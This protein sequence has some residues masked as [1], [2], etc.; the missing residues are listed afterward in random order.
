MQAR[1]SYMKKIADPLTIFLIG[2]TGDLSKKKILKAL[3]QLHVQKALPEQFTLVGNAR[4]KFSREEFV[5][6]AKSHI[7]P[8]RYDRHWDSF[9]DTLFY[10]SGDVQKIKTFTDLRSFH[11]HLKTC[12]NHLWYV[13]TL[14]ELYTDVITNIR[15]VDM[16]QT[17]CGWTKL[18]LEKPF[19]TNLTTSKELNS[20]LLQVFSEDQIY[21]IDHFLAKET[22]QNMLVFR[23]GNGLF[24]HLW[25]N[26]YV[27]HVQI[28]ASETTG[29]KGR[30]TFY[31][32]TGVV[33]DVVQNH[34][35]QMLA[36]TLME[37]P[38]Q[39]NPEEIREKRRAFL[40]TLTLLTTKTLPSHAAFG[41][42]S[43]GVIDGK[44][45]PGYT[46]EHPSLKKSTTETAVALKLFSQAERWK[47]VP[48]YIRA[49]KRMSKRVTEISVVF[50]EP[51]NKMFTQS[52]IQQAPNSLTLRIQPNEGVILR[53][54]VKEPGLAMNMKE[55]PM[56]FCYNTAFTIDLVEAYEKLIFDAVEGDPTLFP[57]ASGIDTAWELVEPLLTYMQTSS[58]RP[59]RYPAGTWGPQSFENLIHEDSRSWIEP[60]QN[61]CSPEY[62]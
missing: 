41:Q 58:F 6:F 34:V 7:Q 12:G 3:Y 54:N 62:L 9:A 40:D 35:L 24:E 19:G 42:Y 37:E 11:T 55:V 36:M 17:Q 14:P 28:T 56:S 57:Q 38:T 30:E 59:D 21:R 47:G 10:V 31:D 44:A 18:L 16:E 5:Q 51:S 39:I 1:L 48:I 2:A 8:S 29:I 27:D 53:L 23:F 43:T 25:N 60:N 20:L 52:E 49:G 32:A 22:V 26:K 4:K 33:R 61:V 45:V 13:A 50:K 15:K 46:K